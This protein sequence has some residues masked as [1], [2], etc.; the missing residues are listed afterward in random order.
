MLAIRR[1]LWIIYCMI[2]QEY[3]GSRPPSEFYPQAFEWWDAVG[4]VVDGHKHRDRGSKVLKLAVFAADH[5][6]RQIDGLSR[7]LIGPAVTNLL[8]FVVGFP[9][10][11]GL[12]TYEQFVDTSDQFITDVINGVEGP[13]V[14]IGVSPVRIEFPEEYGPFGALDAARPP[15]VFPS[16]MIANHHDNRTQ[17]RL[18][19]EFPGNRVFND[20]LLDWGGWDVKYARRGGAIILTPEEA[21]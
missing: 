15:K 16:V 18:G 12:E 3:I 9:E 6:R 8:Q 21:E 19:V 5:Y 11:H 7:R 4:T 13:G 10:E 20:V 1:K 17:M 14:N 2:T